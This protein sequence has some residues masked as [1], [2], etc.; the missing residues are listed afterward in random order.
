MKSFT[1][2]WL[3]IPRWVRGLFLGI[4]NGS[5]IYDDHSYMA[6]VFFDLADITP[7]ILVS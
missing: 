4:R 2:L 5:C 6:V 3:D 1:A 7:Y